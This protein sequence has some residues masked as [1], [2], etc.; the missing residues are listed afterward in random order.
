[1]YTTTCIL[2]KLLVSQHK[3]P[4]KQ[5]QL[6]EWLVM[7]ERGADAH[8]LV[9]KCR[10]ILHLVSVFVIFGKS[11]ATRF[12]KAE[13]GIDSRDQLYSL[14]LTQQLFLLGFSFLLPFW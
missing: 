1:M 13:F 5:A 6:L 2:Q 12:E 14:Q 9:R 11:Y 7:L 8:L 3:R 10:R 4:T